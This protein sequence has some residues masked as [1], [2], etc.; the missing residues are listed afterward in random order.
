MTQSKLPGVQ[1]PSNLIQAVERAASILDALAQCGQGAGLGTLSARVGLSKGTTHRILSSLMY[2]DFVRQ[3]TATRDY[4]LGFKLVELGSCLLEQI[5]LRKEAEQFLHD[6]SRRTNETTYL[7]ILNRTEVIYLEK[8]ESEDASTVLRATAKVGQRNAANSCAVGK[9]LLAELPDD[10]LDALIREMPLIQKTENTITDPLQLKEHL[11]MVRARGYAVDDEE[12]ERGIRCVA[13][14]VRDE[15]GRAV[16]AVSI[17]GPAIRVTR[18]RIQDSLIDEVMKSALEI[19]RKMGFR[20]E[21]KSFPTTE[22]AR[23]M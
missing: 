15:R 21:G 12:S 19:S 9:T 11:K 10:E 6:L 18:Q 7:V 2:L 3:D 8:I 23:R 4:A 16:A 17:S 14:P 22:D 5:D 20:G 13:A 1:K